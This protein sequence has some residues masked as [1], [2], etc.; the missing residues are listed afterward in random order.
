M[1]PNENVGKLADLFKLITK[2]AYL[3][4]YYIFQTVQLQLQ[5]REVLYICSCVCVMMYIMFFIRPGHFLFMAFN[6]FHPD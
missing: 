2:I 6:P 3:Y 4:H 5:K 1:S